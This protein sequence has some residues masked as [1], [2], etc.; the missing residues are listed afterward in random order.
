[1]THGWT[2]TEIELFLLMSLVF[3]KALAAWANLD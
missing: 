1:M 2:H 3:M